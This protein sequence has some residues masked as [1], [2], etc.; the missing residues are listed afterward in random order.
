VVFDIAALADPD[1]ALGMYGILMEAGDG[2]H[3]ICALLLVDPEKLREPR[4]RV[5]Y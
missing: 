5:F 1:T 3:E 2:L 4:E